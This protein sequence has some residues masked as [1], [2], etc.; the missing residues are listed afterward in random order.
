MNERLG[1]TRLNKQGTMMKIVRYGSYTDIDV[2]FMDDFHY[3][4]EHQAYVNFKNGGIKNPY[5]RTTY[6]VGYLGDGIYMAK[7]NNKIVE[8]Y[9]VWHD[10]MRRCYSE[11]SKD[12]FPAYYHICTVSEEWHDYQNFAKWFNDNKYEVNE[13]LHIDKDILCPGNKKYCEEMCMLV[14]Q[15]INMLFANKP[16]KRGLPNGIVQ[17]KHGFL[18]KY[19]REEYGIKETLDEAF[20]LYADKKKEAII[21]IANEYKSVIPNKLY[22]ALLSYEV[23]IDVDKNYIS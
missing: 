16:N 20:E 15:R 2:E 14:P 22:E 21:N 3:I 18:V 11:H 4:K 17:Y 12:R 8:G 10:I 1:E 6:G 13:R 23:R 7:E 9:R 5:D 19:A